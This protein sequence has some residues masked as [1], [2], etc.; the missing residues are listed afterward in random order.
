MTVIDPV[1][2]KAFEKLTIT[3]LGVLYVG[4]AF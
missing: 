1:L 3:K 2:G 4:T